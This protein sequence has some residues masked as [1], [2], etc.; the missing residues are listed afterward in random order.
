MF[1]RA[2]RLDR[3]TFARTYKRGRRVDMPGFVLIYEVATVCTVAA[4]VGKKVAKSAVAR[5]LLRRRLYAALL[6]AG[7]KTGRVIIIAKPAARAYSYDRLRVEVATTLR[8]AA[9]V[10]ASAHSR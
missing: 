5:N 2:H 9:G 1:S 4:V 8:Q 3:A 7:I 10:G 6:D